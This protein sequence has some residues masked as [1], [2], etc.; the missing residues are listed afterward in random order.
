MK[1]VITRIMGGLGNQLFC[2]AA[3]RRLALVNDAELVI[4]D[5]TGFTRDREYKR[6]YMLDNFNISA[7]KATPTERLEPFERYRRVLRKYMS[8]V[9]PFERRKYLKQEGIEFDPRL[10]DFEVRGTVYLEG[11][12][13]S[14][15]YFKDIA[16]IIRREFSFKDPLADKNREIAEL[17]SSVC[18]VSIHFRRGDYVTNAK[19]RE[20]HGIL[21]LKYYNRCL[22]DITQKTPYP[23]LF[24]FSDDPK[25][26]H[27]NCHYD[28]PHLILESNGEYAGH[29]DLRLMSFCKHHIIANSSF[30][31]WGAW[32]S[33]NPDKLVYAPQKWFADNSRDTKDLIPE[34][35][36]RM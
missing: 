32:L 24:I 1:K 9:K 8:Q 13:Q 17:I 3:A 14:E 31:W 11:Y 27:D 34:R 19:A 7:R 22:E 21:S 5:V 16:P 18:S 25:W 33:Q 35:W 4:D 20:T 29:E 26:C 15:K 36:I 28:F 2:Y 10:L 6:K 30:S 23:H 12:W